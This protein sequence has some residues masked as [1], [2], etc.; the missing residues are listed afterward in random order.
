MRRLLREPAVY[1]LLLFVLACLMILCGCIADMRPAISYADGHLR[2]VK[3]VAEVE[4]GRASPG[5]PEREQWASMDFHARRG[6]A[7]TDVMLDHKGAPEIPCPVPRVPTD[8]REVAQEDR[9]LQQ[10]EA[11]VE[12][13]RALRGAASNWLGGLVGAGAGGGGILA[14][15]LP[16]LRRMQRRKR[17]QEAEACKQKRRADQAVKKLNGN[18]VSA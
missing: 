5:S 7:W 3:R 15:A 10:Y 16:F 18:G 14:I 6:L 11:E 4:V 2:E 9:L 17:E 12:T 1:A 13:E 8:L